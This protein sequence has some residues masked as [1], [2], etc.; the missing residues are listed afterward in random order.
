MAAVELPDTVAVR[1]ARAGLI[2]ILG[3][4]LTAQLGGA[5]SVPLV[6]GLIWLR[7]E[8]FLGQVDGEWLPIVRVGQPPVAHSEL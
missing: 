5:L 1:N 3:G 4:C 7:R 6:D 8:S 2:L